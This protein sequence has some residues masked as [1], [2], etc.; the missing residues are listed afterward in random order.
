MI[1]SF[2]YL[3]NFY[4]FNCCVYHVTTI[5]LLRRLFLLAFAMNTPGAMFAFCQIVLDTLNSILGHGCFV[6]ARL[7]K[8]SQGDT[9]VA[10]LSMRFHE[11]RRPVQ[12]APGFVKA[13]NVPRGIW[14]TPRPHGMLLIVS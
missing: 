6:R 13:L 10:I 3:G 4:S 1:I 14:D 11:L 5:V 7:L 8:F 2:C 9:V 12:L